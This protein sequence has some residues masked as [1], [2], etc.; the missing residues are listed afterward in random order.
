MSEQIVVYPRD[1][2]LGVFRR[3]LID[4]VDT[5]FALTVSIAV[6]ILLVVF[7]PE[8]PATY[9]VIAAAWIAIWFF[10]FVLLKGSRFRTLGY[11]LAGAKIVNFR[12]ERPRRIALTARLVFAVFGPFNF[13]L[14]LLWVSSDS[15]G[16]A[17]RDKFAHTFVVRNDA[18]PAGIE[19]AVYRMYFVFGAFLLVPEIQRE[20]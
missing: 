11:A 8:H 15:Y 5:T 19:R 2:Y 9:L 13:L 14:D 17:L 6:T 4:A 1:A 12:G 20:S 16:Q 7:G 3:L 18:V 10:Y